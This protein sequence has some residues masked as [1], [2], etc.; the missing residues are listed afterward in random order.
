MECGKPRLDRN[1][2]EQHGITY[3]EDFNGGTNET[4]DLLH[5]VVSAR[6]AVL[7]VDCLIPERFKEAF[8]EEYTDHFHN[9]IDEDHSNIVLPPSSAYIPERKTS[10]TRRVFAMATAVGD[11]V[12]ESK[13]IAA[14]ARFNEK[15][16]VS[17]DDW[18]FFLQTNIFKSFG[19]EYPYPPPHV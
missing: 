3:E 14:K 17:E 19:E 1:T 7:H 15:A 16:H 18:V 11:I 9:V 6:D 5:H 4:S 2:L 10:D 12:E 13:E 8:E